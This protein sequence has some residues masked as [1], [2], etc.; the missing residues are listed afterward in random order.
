MNKKEKLAVVGLG[1]VGLPLAVAF[2]KKVSVI[3][4]DLNDKKIE[5][6]RKGIDVTQ[7][8]GEAIKEATI[9][10]T[11]N[12]E[13]LAEAKFII[14]A[15]PTPINEDKTPDLGPVITACHSV[16]RHLRKGTIVVFESTVYP[17]VTENE[18]VPILEQESGLVCGRDFKVGYSPERINPGDKVNRLT[19]ITKIVSGMDKETL[20]C[21]A[22]VYELIIEAGVHRAKSIKV[23]EA[24]KLVEN[25]QR[26]INIA[27]MNEIAKVFDLIGIDTQEVVEAMN[28]KWNSLGFSPGLVGGHCIGVD[29]Y[30][31]IYQAKALSYEPQ[32]I[33]AS[34]VINESMGLFV[35]DKI[36]QCLLNTHKELSTARVYIMGGTFKENCPDMRNTRVIDMITRLKTYGIEPVISDP[37]AE[38]E[39]LKTYFGCEVVE[40]E[41]V[42]DADCMVFAVAHDCFK[43]LTLECLEAMYKEIPDKE[44]VLIDIKGIFDKEQIQQREYTYWRL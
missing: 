10:Y 38:P 4:F 19:Q 39:E 13:M 24:A 11:S 6:Y 22:K 36:V 1:Y 18:C 20:E 41:A 26:D 12:E 17:G 33:T 27:F 30:Y 34:R 3:G 2:D 23:A 25:T 16:G 28:T 32:V 43:A 9:V 15:V 5:A 44:K 40:I 37:V 21:I 31:F 8:V 29:P 35:A 42:E 7:E 14:V